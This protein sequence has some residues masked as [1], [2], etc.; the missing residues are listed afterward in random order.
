MKK[1]PANVQVALG[2]FILLLLLSSGLPAQNIIGG[3]TGDPTAILDLRSSNKG[4]LLPR[5]SSEERSAIVNPAEGL[6]IYNTSLGCLELNLGSSQTP[7]WVC[8]DARTGRLAGLQC[9]MV[10]LPANWLKGVAVS[11]L[12]IAVPYT[13]GN[14]GSHNGQTVASSGV[15]GLTATLYAGS[16]ANGNGTLLYA[17]SGTP[18]SAGTASFAINIG[19]ASCLL[20]VPVLS[21]GAYLSPGT[22][23]EFMC[24]NLG[25][26]TSVDP[27]T[28]SWELIGNY[29]QWGRNPTCF[30]HD[31]TDLPNPCSSP[32]YGAAGPWGGTAN[33]DNAGSITGWS[34]TAAPNGAWQDTVKTANDP[35]PSGFRL[36]T[37]LQ[38]QTVINTGL[39]TR[40]FVG[41]WTSSST[42]YTS[43]IK[44][45]SSLLLP[46]AGNR[47]TSDGT[48][49][50]RGSFGYYWSSTENT[51]TSAWYLEFGSGNAGTYNG[52]R[53]DGFSVRCIAE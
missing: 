16:F 40:E 35:C 33:T 43:G 32:V 37:R 36:P 14:G 34:T 10:S 39:N 17:V 8:M 9:D 19:G 38:W 52:N 2:T 30:G 47:F 48:L 5:M 3:S 4:L 6:L 12:V 26:N 23:K 49:I 46:A 24:H 41:T 45:G 44:F 22:L 15:T 50:N 51:S 27:L 29:Y 1:I 53:A 25:A 7:D 21:C 20:Q 13:G 31:N 42:S 11:G 28:P 18:M